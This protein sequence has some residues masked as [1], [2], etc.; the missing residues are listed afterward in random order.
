[1]SAKDAD[2]IDIP[3]VFVGELSGQM[4][5]GN[6]QYQHDFVLVLNGDLPFDINTR[7][8]LPFS[9]VVGLCFLIMM[10]FVIMKCMRE[11]RRQRRHRLPRS[12]LKS[13]PVLKFNKLTMS[14][15]TCIICLDDYTDGEKIRVLPCDHGENG[16]WF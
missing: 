6:Y 3:S 1:M 8:I 10:G 13:I 11:R 7:L 2:G 9:I 4:L 16:K 15:E 14:Y 5:L 12:A